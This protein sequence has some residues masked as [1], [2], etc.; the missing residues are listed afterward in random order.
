MERKIT[1]N[2]SQVNL[3]GLYCQKGTDYGVVIA[4]PHPLYGGDMYNPVVESLALCCNKRNITTLRFNFRSVGG[5]EGT[6][7]NGDGEQQDIVAAVEY[8]VGQGVGKVLVAGYSFGSWV[9]GKIPTFPKNV[10][11]LVFVSPPI[12]LL[13]FAENYSSTLLKLVVTG[14]NDEIAPPALVKDAVAV[15]NTEASYKVI[16][17]ADHFYFGCFPALDATF[18]EYLKSLQC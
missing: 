9:V 15:W 5:S 16:D 1:F 14:E 18:N 2:S 6:Y 12:A 8:L 4:H 11:G 10:E 7:D 13:P 3:E 17:F